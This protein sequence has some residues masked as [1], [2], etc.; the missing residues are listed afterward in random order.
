MVTLICFERDCR[1][2]TCV[3]YESKL[4]ATLRGSR[5]FH[6]I[7]V[8]GIERFRLVSSFEIQVP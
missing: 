2:G 6:T 7:G 8:G 5:P 4:I 3:P 1:E